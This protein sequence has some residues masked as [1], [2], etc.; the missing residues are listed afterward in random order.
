[1]VTLVFRNQ[2]P[3]A[4]A[5]RCWYPHTLSGNQRISHGPISEC[6]VSHAGALQ[7]LE[8]NLRLLSGSTL[9]GV[10]GT[11]CMDI[12]LHARNEIV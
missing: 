3:T 2:T 11:S 6:Q 10:R 4:H 5:F 12:K 8:L 1:M 9:E 7:G